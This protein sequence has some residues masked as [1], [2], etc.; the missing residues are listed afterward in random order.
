MEELTAE[1]QSY[2]D[3]GLCDLFTDFLKTFKKDGKYPYIVQIDSNLIQEKPVTIDYLDLTS[4][5]QYV[6]DSNPSRRIQQA[7][8]RAIG[9]VFQIRAGSATRQDMQGE[10]SIRIKIVNC[11]TMEEVFFGNVVNE[12]ESESK[13]TKSK[14]VID[15]TA[16]KIMEQYQLVTLRSTDEILSHNGKIYSKSNAESIIRE[17][18]EKIIENCTTHDRSEVTNKI[19][20]RTYVDMESFDDDAR[21]IT[22]PNCVLNIETLE[23]D[24]HS[25]DYLSRILLPVEYVDIPHPID[26]AAIFENLEENLKNTLFW[27]F[28]KSSFTVDGAFR[29][30][31]FET[32]LEITASFFVKRQIDERAFMFL[33][34]GENG[35]SVLLE[36]IESLLGKDNIEHIQLQ[37]LSE[38]KFMCAHLAG[39]MA[40]IF[41][42]LERDELRYTG[43]I[44]SIISNE[45]IEVQHK[46]KSAF[47][48]YPFLKLL[49][50]CN[51][52]PKVYD[53]SQDFFRRWIIVKWERDFEG[54]PER[55]EHLKEKLAGNQ[56]EKSLVFSCLVHLARKLNKTGKFTHSKNWKEIQKEWNA[57]AD[58]IDDFATNY[59]VDSDGNKTK[60]ETYQFYKEVM[61][62]KGEI[63]L[64]IGQFGKAFSQY[65]EDDKDKDEYGRSTRVWLNIA[66]KEAKQLEMKEF[67]A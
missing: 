64:G 10:D 31:E 6:V 34:K 21:I 5:I 40:N 38:D 54:D 16:T 52:F 4:E 14:S 48:L 22:T 8:Y 3:S 17:E 23:V 49:F 59:I 9:E 43:K 66:F 13:L 39:K 44:K 45:G 11:P 2:T 67:D 15:E 41:P 33:G 1:I 61:F 46:Y 24:K 47:K 50:S 37:D 53:Q 26:D 56:D 51:R 35:K 18:S 55:D 57:N 32:V 63:P 25:P 65:Y 42:D 20:A 29:Q 28:L 58:P 62:S 30:E 60:R 12:H 36:Y 27:K 19:K 7:V